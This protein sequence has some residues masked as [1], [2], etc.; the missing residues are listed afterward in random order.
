MADLSEDW[1]D[2]HVEITDHDVEFTT[3]G[4]WTEDRDRKAGEHRSSETY[5]HLTLDELKEFAR[6]VLAL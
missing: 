1:G 2:I 6:K 5:T 3:Y 4:Y